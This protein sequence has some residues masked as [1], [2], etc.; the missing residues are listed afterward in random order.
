MRWNHVK[1]PGAP[2]GTLC[3]D[4]AARPPEVSLFAYG[5]GRFEEHCLQEVKRI[6]DF[7]HKWPVTW[8]NVDGLG[9][10]ATLKKLAEI[11]NLHILALEDVVH[12]HQRAK[13]DQ[14]DDHLYVVARMPRSGDRPD[15]E[16]VSLF[17]GKDYVITFLE[18]PGDCFDPV[19]TRIRQGHGRL[20]EMG[21]DYL[22]YSLLDSVVDAY[23]PVLERYGE[24]LDELE[25]E[26][27]TRSGP[28]TVARVHDI[29][30]DLLILRRAIW[31]HRDAFNA[32]VRDKNPFIGPEA[33]IYLRD[34]YDHIVQ[35]I[36]LVEMYRE[37]GS[38]L[39]DL[40]YNSVSNR[41]NQIMKVL[42][43]ITT[44]F[45]PLTLIAGIYGMNFDPDSS[46]WNMPE[47]RWRWGYPVT[48]AGMALVTVAMLI[49]FRRKG[50]LGEV[51]GEL[52][53]IGKDANN[54]HRESEQRGVQGNGGKK[55][56]SGEQK[57][58]DGG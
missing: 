48:L 27:V 49:L 9:D 18:D 1:P 28:A 51:H 44:I 39:R 58:R 2:P 24:R 26:V 54:A 3:I 32:L 23:F 31:P 57:K 15:T 45:M 22:A 37:L 11:F 21:A 5:P 47:L 12:V 4:P 46:P 55:P 52:T 56:E 40:H 7:L 20:R 13:V 17:V 53:A 42:T 35:I 25:Q 10:A 33:I 6:G 34:C 8:V 36:D 19:R 29:K 41:M 16:Q 30:T 38:D 43:V 50:W 14:F